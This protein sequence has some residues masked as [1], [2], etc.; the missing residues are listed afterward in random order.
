MRKKRELEIEKILNQELV[1]TQ[2]Q[3]FA[4]FNNHSEHKLFV[5]P[6]AKNDNDIFL[7]CMDCRKYVLKV[8]N[9]EQ[10]PRRF[11]LRKHG[12]TNGKGNPAIPKQLR[13][14]ISNFP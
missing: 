13:D 6:V 11:D 3:L 10:T 14:T 7:F 4:V 2:Q 12:F 1:K 9:S 5:V 8:W